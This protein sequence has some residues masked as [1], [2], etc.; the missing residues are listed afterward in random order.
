MNVHLCITTYNRPAELKQCVEAALRSDTELTSIT[1]LDNST[2]HYAAEVLGDDAYLD[3]SVITVP[4]NIGWG[5][6]LNV[7]FALYDDY[8]VCC[9]DDLAVHSHTIRELVDSAQDFP[10]DALFYGAHDG[11]SM[12]SLFLL[13][14]QAYLEMGPFDPAIWPFYYD[15]IDALYRL[16]LLGYSPVTVY[17][18][19]YDHVKNGTLKAFD[20]E[21]KA[22]HERQ[23]SRNE[24]YYRAKWGGLKFQETYTRPFNGE[25]PQVPPLIK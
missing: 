15:D 8:I 18:A 3:V 21:R 9:N 5:A 24:A 16:K 19:T 25:R 20:P 2:E 12:W 7:F 14:K 10:D 11:E 6:A 1:V 13:R 22:L 17:P 4:R 23:F